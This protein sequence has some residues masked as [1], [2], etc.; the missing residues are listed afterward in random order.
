MSVFDYI[1][2]IWPFL[3]GV[4]PIVCAALVLW[5]QSMFPTKANI[6][7]LQAALDAKLKGM[8]QR[9]SDK[10][11]EHE[12]RLDTG[13]KKMADLDKR[14]ALEED[15]RRQAPTRA[16]MAAHIADLQAGYARLEA[17]IDGFG[18]LLETQNEYLHTLI[19]QGLNGARK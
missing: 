18:R 11:D 16:E 10:I 12:E 13:S 3:S 17:K 19:E 4:A 7:D 2:A 9:L 6:T 8:E 14:L 1:Q 5:L 15:D